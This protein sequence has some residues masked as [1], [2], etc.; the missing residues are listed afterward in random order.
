MHGKEDLVA[1]CLHAEALAKRLGARLVLL[2]GAHFI[3]REC[4]YEVREN[5][6]MASKIP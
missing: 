4:S 3:P 5:R 1:E 6:N 2:Q